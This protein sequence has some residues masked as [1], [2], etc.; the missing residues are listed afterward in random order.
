VGAVAVLLDDAEVAAEVYRL[1]LPTARYCTGDGSGQVF[2][3][4]SNARF[5]ADLA[6]TCGRADEAI[7][8]YADA[9]TV[10]LRLGARPFV[11]LSRLGWARALL[12]RHSAPGS[13][14]DDDSSA[15]ATASRLAGQAAAEFRRLDMPGPLVTAGRLLTRLAS[16]SRRVSPLSVREAEVAAL[17]AEALSNRE[18]ADRLYLSE[19]TVESHVRNILAKLGFST[20]TEVATWAV[21]QG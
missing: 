18:I 13:A 5:L 14:A 17:V 11:A 15:L 6:V 7:R 19:R 4:G 8:L 3:L 21:R 9:I 1:L 10:N 2:S 16:E 12:A 20:R